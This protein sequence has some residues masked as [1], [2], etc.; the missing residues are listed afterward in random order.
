MSRRLAIA[1]IRGYQILIRPLLSGSC[2]Y[3]P[4]CSEYA[5]DAVALH[6]VIKGSWLGIKRV[7]RCHPL[8][9]AGLDPVP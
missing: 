7:C 3:V 4:T 5:I 8:G 6:G 2:R 9:G 1:A